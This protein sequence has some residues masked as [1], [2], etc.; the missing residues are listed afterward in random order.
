MNTIVLRPDVKKFAKPIG[1]MLFA[2]LLTNY[3][4][5]FDKRFR[6]N[7]ILQIFS[8]ALSIFILYFIYRFV[9][10]IMRINRPIVTITESSIQFNDNGSLVL[11]SW[12]DVLEWS[13][14][15][16]GG[17]KYLLLK[18]AS[19]QRKINIS[20]LNRSPDKIKN[21]ISNLK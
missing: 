8:I 3:F 11:F 4:A 6:N 15:E 21:I 5:F 13:I 17:S 19:G 1:I 9:S 7:L 16:E 2:L 12:N 10:L 18:T 14:N 20:N